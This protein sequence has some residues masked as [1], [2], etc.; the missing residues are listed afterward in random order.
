MVVEERL[1]LG[2]IADANSDLLRKWQ[3]V[4]QEVR[5]AGVGDVH[6][7]DGPVR[8][9]TVLDAAP[10]VGAWLMPDNRSDGELE[11]FVA[12]MIPEADPIWLLARS[13]IDTIPPEHK[14]FSAHH[15]VRAQVY[16]WTVALQSPGGLLSAA[17]RPSQLDTTS[18]HARRLVDWIQ[19]LFE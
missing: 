5:K 1:A 19:H 3:E 13:Y 17:T 7:P 16:A 9:G 11:Y 6:I 12:T 14:K 15:T 4:V 8:G 18:E 2:I 10:R